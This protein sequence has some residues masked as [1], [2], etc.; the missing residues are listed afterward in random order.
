MRH[1]CLVRLV[2]AAAAKL[3]REEEAAKAAR[4]AEAQAARERAE[5]EERAAKERAFYQSAYLEEF[6]C[7]VEN[8]DGNLEPD[9]NVYFDTQ[10][11]PRSQKLQ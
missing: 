6:T 1:D 9:G 11:R 2:E 8:R 7:R 10:T 4:D 5:A 3:R